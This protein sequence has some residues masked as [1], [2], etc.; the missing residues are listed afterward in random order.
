[1]EVA[2]DKNKSCKKEINKDNF[3]DFLC[4][5]TP[6]DLNKL[7]LEEGKPIKAYNPI[8]LFDNIK[9]PKSE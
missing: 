6:E 7:I 3:I 5:S 2:M 4:Q 9:E 8:I 1:M